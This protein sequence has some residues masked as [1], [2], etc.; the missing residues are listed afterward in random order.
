MIELPYKFTQFM[1]RLYGQRGLEWVKNL[2]QLIVN[3]EE[4]WN[5]RVQA[6]FPVLSYNFA[7]PAT[8]ADGR[9]V[10]V[11]IGVPNRE[12][13]TEIAAL[14]LYNGHGICRLYAADPDWG[15]LVIERLRPGTMLLDMADDAAATAV[16][17]QVM[18]KLWRPV[19]NN[20]I[21]KF[22][23]IARWAHGLH[24]LRAQ[25]NGGTGPFPRKL[26]ETAE[27]IFADLLASTSEPV[28]LHGDLHHY[29]ILSATRQPW[30]AIDPKGVI[31]E[32]CYEVGAFMRNP[33]DL[34]KWP[35]LQQ[36]LS[37][38]ADVFADILGFERE[39]ILAWSLA[40]EIL[41]KWWDYEDIEQDWNN[42][43]IVAHH[44]ANL[45]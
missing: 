9:E 29:N 30:L 26:I 42:P 31:G 35:D 19:P 6:P 17:A 2:P 32:P 28:L 34:A 40:Q 14:R 22:P 24:D 41:S 25:F 44:L 38:R 27:S 45:L 13:Y 1:V 3:C 36:V 4:R 23:T 20:D 12:L 7:A 5:L 39:R 8:Y 21:G 15:V 37:R 11:K 43:L 33:L 16:A 10:V 18:Q